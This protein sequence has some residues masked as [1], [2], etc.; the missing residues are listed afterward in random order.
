MSVCTP[1]LE[2]PENLDY[3][4]ELKDRG[5]MVEVLNPFLEYFELTERGIG[6]LTLVDAW[7]V[8]SFVFF[9]GHN[10]SPLKN[11]CPYTVLDTGSYG[12]TYRKFGI[13]KLWQGRVLIWSGWLLR[14]FL[15]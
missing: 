14:L 10:C 12:D 8:E 5:F 2:F 11:L 6:F 4:E 15:P 13:V 9:A 7:C 1:Y 3:V